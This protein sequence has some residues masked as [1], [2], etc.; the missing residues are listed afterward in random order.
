MKKVYICSFWAAAGTIAFV[1][2]S[3]I[4]SVWY[5]IPALIFIVATILLIII[6]TEVRKQ[7]LKISRRIK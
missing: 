5:L 4:V 1:I 7:Q 6:V 2:L 3:I